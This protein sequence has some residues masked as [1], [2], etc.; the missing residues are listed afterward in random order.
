MEGIKVQVG[1]GFLVGAWENKKIVWLEKRGKKNW[2]KKRR[3][4]Y[5]EAETNRAQIRELDCMITCI[6]RRRGLQ[7]R[8]A[9]G[10]AA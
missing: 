9:I 2:R 7:E 8:R 4:L 3:Y 1:G 6:T 10:F 5:P